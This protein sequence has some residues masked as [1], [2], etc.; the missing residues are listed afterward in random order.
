MLVRPDGLLDQR[1]T[2]YTTAVLRARSG[3]YHT[4]IQ[5]LY[6]V[7]AFRRFT[8]SRR[9]DLEER[10]VAGRFLMLHGWNEFAQE[11]GARVEVATLAV[12][13]D[14]AIH[15][16]AWCI[17][18]RAV[19]ILDPAL[20]AH[21]EGG[22]TL[23]LDE[24]SSQIP[25]GGREGTREPLSRERRSQLIGILR[26]PAELERLWPDP[27]ARV[28]N[29]TLLWW[30]LLLGHRIGE[31]LNLQAVDLDLGVMR[32]K[33]ERRHD[34]PDDPRPRQPLV[35]GR[36]RKLLIPSVLLP[37]LSRY[38]TARAEM[39]LTHDYLFVAESLGPLSY[40][41]VAKVFARLREVHPSLAP[42]SPHVLRHT[43]IAA[44]RVVAREMGLGE[45]EEGRIES[46]AMGWWD[47]AS[48]RLYA[49]RQRAEVAD[50]ISLRL[51]R[52][53]MGN[54]GDAT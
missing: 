9:I 14:A 51:Q 53:M 12:R 46:V 54:E 40:S 1:A 30:L 28:R 27:F 49:A 36:G 44:F 34:S 50:E 5:A 22:A 4:L 20:H 25:V 23:F 15:F 19:R 33:I 31:V 32:L 42:L 16:V 52:K 8:A 37:A 48:D 39:A 6:G 11:V 10:I 13:M 2:V 18:C 17:R 41:A 45:E 21:F 26:C 35:K 7:L 3:S 38:L 24:A 47:P 43:W 29:E